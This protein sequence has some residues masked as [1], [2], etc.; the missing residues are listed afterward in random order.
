MTDLTDFVT[1]MTRHG[2]EYVEHRD[3]Q[4]IVL[5]QKTSDGFLHCYSFDEYGKF[6]RESW[7]ELNNDTV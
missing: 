7:M 5:Y 2:I 1:F 6:L 4:Y 3:G